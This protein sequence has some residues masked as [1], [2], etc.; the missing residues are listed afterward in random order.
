MLSILI[1]FAK[2]FNQSECIKMSIVLD[3]PTCI[4]LNFEH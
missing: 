1:G 3:I 2:I 4:T